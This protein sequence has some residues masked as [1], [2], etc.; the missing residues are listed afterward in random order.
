MKAHGFVQIVPERTPSGGVRRL[1]MAR[2]SSKF[3]RQP[4]PGSITVRVV[5]DI[6]DEIA[7]VQTAEAAVKAG[8]VTITIPVMEEPAP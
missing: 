4:L 1:T 3:P 7:S 2:V 5:L 6:P 8:A